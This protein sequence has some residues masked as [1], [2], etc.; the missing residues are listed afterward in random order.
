MLLPSA[1]AM[2][3]T[4]LAYAATRKRAKTAAADPPEEHPPTVLCYRAMRVLCAV[5]TDVYRAMLSCEA[6]AT[7]CPVLMSRMALL[8]GSDEMYLMSAPKVLC[9]TVSIR[10]WYDYSALHY[11]SPV[12]CYT[13]M[14]M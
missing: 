5:G 2:P 6:C 10:F 11:Y 13:D 7:R 8:P 1:Y 3:G 4:E 9:P 12:A 14:P